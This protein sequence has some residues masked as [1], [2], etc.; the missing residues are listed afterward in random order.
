VTTD[1][2]FDMPLAFARQLAATYAQTAA[3]QALNR[4][5]AL[6]ASSAALFWGGEPVLLGPPALAPAIPA[7]PAAAPL[8]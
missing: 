5:I 1:P 3:I 2:P 6:Q 4:D 7:P 8:T